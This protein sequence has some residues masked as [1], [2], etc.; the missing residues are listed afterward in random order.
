MG[1]DRLFPIAVKLGLVSIV[2]VG[3]SLLPRAIERPR[4]VMRLEKV[5]GKLLPGEIIEL[6]GKRPIGFQDLLDRLGD[7]RII[8]VGETHNDMDHHDVQLEILEGLYGRDPRLVIGMEMFERTFQSVLDQWTDGVIDRKAL[9]R[10]SEWFSRWK[11]DFSYYEKIFTFAREKEIKILALNAPRELVRKVRDFGEKGLSRGE[12]AM[13]APID[14]SDT[15]HRRYMQRV[16][17]AHHKTSGKT[18][19]NFYEAQCVWDDTMAETIADF[20]TSRE[21]ENTRVIVFCGAGHMVYKF[22]IPM[23][24]FRRTGFPYATILPSGLKR[25]RE[26]FYEDERPPSLALADFLWITAGSIRKKAWLG[27][28]AEKSLAHEKGLVVRRVIKGSSADKAGIE[29]GD[30]ILSVDE[31]TINDMVDLRFA[32]SRKEPGSVS[33][34]VYL[35]DG[36]R[37]EAKVTFSKKGFH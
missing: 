34:V 22:G 29:A 27:V 32:L 37:I 31:Q 13:I 17:K 21:G 20:V 18:F 35:R 8:Y 15:L 7:K 19:Q 33:R 12:K 36:K 24:A 9:L 1:M 10:Q 5:R 6:D 3:C 28:V 23:R 25:I 16:F 26:E 2:L 4:W 11:F 14:T 30:T